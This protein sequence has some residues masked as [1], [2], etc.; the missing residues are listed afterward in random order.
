M[1]KTGSASIA[2]MESCNGEADIHGDEGDEEQED[3]GEAALLF[4]WWR[5]FTEDGGHHQHDGQVH[6]SGIAKELF[7]KE[8]GD[9]GDEEQEDGGEV[10]GQQLCGNLPLQLQDHEHHVGILLL[11]QGQVCYC[12][13]GQ[14]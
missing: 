8:D 14:I 1:N 6:L 7:V 2:L 12:E 3:G 5:I 9:K 13:H 11:C 4:C 10:G